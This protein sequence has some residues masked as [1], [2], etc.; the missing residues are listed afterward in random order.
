MP[1][2]EACARYWTP[3]SLPTTGNCPT[4]GRDLR[5]P[6]GSDSHTSSDRLHAHNLDI[7]K[8]AG[9]DG[10]DATTPWHFKM[11]MVGLA[12]YLTWRIV[13]LFL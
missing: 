11:L 10:E 12:L 4:C 6:Q 5:S 9:Q 3:S 8:L 2:C 7:R 13:A 1:F